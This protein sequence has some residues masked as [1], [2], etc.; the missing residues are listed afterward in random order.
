VRAII[1]AGG[2]GTRV[3]SPGPKALVQVAGRALLEWVLEE[4]EGLE[5]TIL[6]RDDALTAFEHEPWLRGVRISVAKADTP[7]RSIA[8]EV[9]VG[10]IVVVLH[11]DELCL[12]SAG[13]RC[14]SAIAERFNLPVVGSSAAR[15]TETIRLGLSR[16]AEVVLEDDERFPPG[17]FDPLMMDIGAGEAKWARRS[18]APQGVQARYIGRYAFRTSEAL[19]ANLSVGRSVLGAILASS[20][21]FVA[22]D[23]PK[24]YQDCG[25]DALL[26][27]A[28]E[29]IGVAST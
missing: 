1:L 27:L 25:T 10:E 18:D 24:T 12:G 8:R 3:S 2:L 15:L 22:A 21:R 23:L 20:A 11:T 9:S 16:S 6:V 29:Q 4:T 28:D 13:A 19:L 7:A 5:T 26:R 14:Y 17:E